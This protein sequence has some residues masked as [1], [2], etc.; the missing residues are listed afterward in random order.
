MATTTTT[1]TA[2]A[3]PQARSGFLASK[4]GRERL[5]SIVATILC[6]V[7]AIIILF[8]LAWMISTSLKTRAE[9]ARFPPAWIPNIPQWQNY[10]DALTGQNNFGTYFKNTMIY[11]LGS[12]FG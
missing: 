7:G 8:P 3:R 1:S 2:A 6:I 4:K 12:M 10:P 5:I 9:V 11:S